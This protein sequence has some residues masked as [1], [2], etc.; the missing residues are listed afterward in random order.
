MR[1]V[2]RPLRL[3]PFFDYDLIASLTPGYVGADLLALATRAG[4]LAV[5]RLIQKKQ[6]NA[7]MGSA[8]SSSSVSDLML[9]D[10]LIMQI[11]ID[12]SQKNDDEEVASSPNIIEPMDISNLS[13]EQEN[14]NTKDAEASVSTAPGDNT[15]EQNT[16]EAT[17]TTTTTTSEVPTNSEDANKPTEVKNDETSKNAEEKAP[18]SAVENNPETNAEAPK[19]DDANP[20]AP[21]PVDFSTNETLGGALL[22]NDE[23]KHRMGLETMFKWLSDNNTLV[24]KKDMIN[25]YITA[26]NFKEAIKLVQPSA[27]REGFITVPDVT[28]NDIGSLRDIREELNLA[29]LAPVKFPNRLKQLGITAPSGVLL[30]GP[31]GKNNFITNVV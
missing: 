27:K 28:W 12:L 29:I 23:I 13:K 5:T 3:E 22:K 4:L 14:L 30:C 2:C 21:V 8:N 6:E 17:T 18:E 19:S 20:D 25:L 11:D 26:E 15:S 10:G 16:K 9:E 7:L 24:T 1:I 31:P